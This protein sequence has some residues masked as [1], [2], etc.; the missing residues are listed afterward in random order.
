MSRKLTRRQFVVGSGAVALWAGA[1]GLAVANRLGAFEPAP[2]FDRSVFPKPGASAVA[3]LR[4][5]R[6]DYEAGR[7]SSFPRRYTAG[8]KVRVSSFVVAHVNVLHEPPYDDE[9]AETALDV[10]LTVSLRR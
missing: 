2:P 5:E 9:A 4:A 10:A 8:A 1:G 3:V 6:L 7:F